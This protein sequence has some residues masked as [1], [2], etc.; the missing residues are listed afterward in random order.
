[1]ALPFPE[2]TDE[3]NLNLKDYVLQAIETGNDELLQVYVNYEIF[4]LTESEVAHIASA[5]E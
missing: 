2:L 1:M 5:L 3:Q 4:S